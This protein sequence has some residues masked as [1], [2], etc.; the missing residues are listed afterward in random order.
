MVG[1]HLP[2]ARRVALREHEQRALLQARRLRALQD[3]LEHR[4]GLL[5][6]GM[7]QPLQREQLQLLVGFGLGTHR[8]SGALTHL[9]LERLGVGDPLAGRDSP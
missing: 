8:L 3:L 5:G 2:R 4:H 6:I 9:E 7:L 1:Q